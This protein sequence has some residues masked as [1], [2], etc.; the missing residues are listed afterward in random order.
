[1]SIDVNTASREVL[2]ALRG[3]GEELADTIIGLRPFT[4]IEELLSIRGIGPRTLERLK[5]Q[6]LVVGALP[7][8]TIRTTIPGFYAEA[9]LYQASRHYRSITSWYF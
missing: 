8:E 1:M 3:I 2:I 5:R 7:Q 4:A 6:G 9:S